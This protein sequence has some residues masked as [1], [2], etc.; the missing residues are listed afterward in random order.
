MKNIFDGVPTFRG[1]LLAI[2]SV[3]RNPLC[4]RTT[5][6]WPWNIYEAVFTYTWS[7]N[8]T[9]TQPIPTRVPIHP[10]PIETSIF[11]DRRERKREREREREMI[12][13]VYV[14]VS[15]TQIQDS[16]RPLRECRKIAGEQKKDSS[17][18][19]H[20]H[21]QASPT[22]CVIHTRVH[23]HTDTRRSVVVCRSKREKWLA[24]GR[25]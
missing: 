18:L 5:E 14:R 13:G 12:T 8:I 10:Q 16:I 11:C 7:L 22:A 17:S 23:V 21:A 15:C 2:R 9:I 25:G 3:T 20:I 4:S 24:E 19:L 1:R 6:N